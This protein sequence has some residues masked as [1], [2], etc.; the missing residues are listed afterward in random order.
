[1]PPP[2]PNLELD[3]SNTNTLWCGVLVETLVRRGVRH[4]VIAPGSRSAPLTF[5]FARHPKIEALP[6]VDERSAAFF[7][8]GL[9]RQHHRP[10]ALVCTSGTAAANFLPAVIEAHA[11]GVPLV[12]LTADRPPELR[13]CGAGQAIDQQKIYGGYV[14]FYH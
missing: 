13:A 1:M 5:A 8:L 4:A 10:V 6:V 14:R 9:A 3:Y 2:S 12:V 7:A 11:S